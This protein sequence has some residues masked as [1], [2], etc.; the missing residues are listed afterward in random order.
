VPAY[1]ALCDDVPD[2]AELRRAVL[3]DH[4]TYIEAIMDRVLVAGPL[5]APA[6]EAYSSSCFVYLADDIEA[7]RVLLEEDPYH[8]AGVYAEVRWSEFKPAAGQWI[9]GKTW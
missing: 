1:M 6:T 3:Q 2:S 8:R 9:G 7:A 4:L 5:R